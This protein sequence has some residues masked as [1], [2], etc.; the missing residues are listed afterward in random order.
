[1]PHLYAL[2]CETH[3][4]HRDAVLWQSE[5]ESNEIIDIGRLKVHC[6]AFNRGGGGQ[7]RAPL[8]DRPVICVTAAP[9][10]SINIPYILSQHGFGDGGAGQD[11]SA[12]VGG[13][14]E[15]KKK[16]EIHEEVVVVRSE[17]LLGK[18][19]DV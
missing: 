17:P 13:N 16:S 9:V 14:L 10:C 7:V 18:L 6:E 4:F 2:A 8:F 5:T 3:P 15:V 1:M 19:R 11:G 12:C